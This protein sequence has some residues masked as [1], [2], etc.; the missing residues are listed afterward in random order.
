MVAANI[1]NSH[2]AGDASQPLSALNQ[3]TSLRCSSF[4]F[5]TALYATLSVRSALVNP[6]SRNRTLDAD[7]GPKILGGRGWRVARV[8]M[9]VRVAVG[10]VWVIWLRT[11]T[12]S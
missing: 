2:Y 4:T 8:E 9:W 7:Q 12:I 11:N 1:M 5:L 10:V 3:L 6:I